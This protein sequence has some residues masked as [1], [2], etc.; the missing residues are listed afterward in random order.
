MKFVRPYSNPVVE[1]LVA[2]I[3]RAKVFAWAI[4]IGSLLSFADAFLDW[5]AGDTNVFESNSVNAVE[6]IESPNQFHSIIGYKILRSFGLLLLAGI[7]HGII[8]DEDDFDIFAPDR[9]F[10]DEKDEKGGS[11]SPGGANNCQISRARD[12]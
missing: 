7:V 2:L 1:W 6:Q 11:R 8:G 4:L 10:K 12:D 3:P 9:K 5:R